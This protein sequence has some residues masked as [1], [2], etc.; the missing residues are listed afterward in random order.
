MKVSRG[1]P[2]SAGINRVFRGAAGKKVSYV[3][4]GK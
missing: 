3:G 4:K 2:K 1:H